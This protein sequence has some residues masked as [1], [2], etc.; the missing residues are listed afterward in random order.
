M[1]PPLP[2]GARPSGSNLARGEASR[3]FRTLCGILIVDRQESELCC[4]RRLSDFAEMQCLSDS[5]QNVPPGIE[6]KLGGPNCS[7]RSTDATA[8]S[9]IALSPTSASPTRT[10]RSKLAPGGFQ[11]C[12]FA[13]EKASFSF[14]DF[15]CNFSEAPTTGL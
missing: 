15:E 11:K 6:I 3:L 12:Y 7:G 4:S 8:L 10:R 5:V 9:A 1:N 13:V 14:G 2:H